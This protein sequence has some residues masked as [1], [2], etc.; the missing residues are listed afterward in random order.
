MVKFNVGDI[1]MT[2]NN[3]GIVGKVVE[4]TIEETGRLIY[5]V[6]NQGHFY[7]EDLNARPAESSQNQLEQM[8]TA[9]Q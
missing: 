1:V 9:L 6:E 5:K 8:E 4:L 2:S 7:P 3:P